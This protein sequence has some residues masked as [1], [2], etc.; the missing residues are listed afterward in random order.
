ML[1][2][3]VTHIVLYRPYRAAKDSPRE[4][5]MFNDAREA[6]SFAGSHGRL[7]SSM[8]ACKVDFKL[9]DEVLQQLINA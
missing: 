8:D 9:T 3:K 5:V 2:D 4:C 7:C 1:L 6:M